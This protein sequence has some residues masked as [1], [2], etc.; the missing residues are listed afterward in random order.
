MTSEPKLLTEAEWRNVLSYRK[1]I[2]IDHIRE[3]GLIAEEPVDA[4]NEIMALVRCLAPDHEIEQAIRAI[5]APRKELTLEMM[6]EA[7]EVAQHQARG[8][9]SI[10]P[11]MLAALT[12]AL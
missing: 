11:Y 10:L 2:V 12:E 4:V 5:A 7:W 3:C 9:E 1:D 8:N 6:E